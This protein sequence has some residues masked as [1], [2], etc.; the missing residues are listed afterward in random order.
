MTFKLAR[1]VAALMLLGAL[2]RNPYDYYTILR[3]VVCPIAG[4]GAVQANA[5]HDHTW[6]WIFGVIA[7]LHNPIVPVHLSRATWA[8]IDIAC[9][10]ALLVSFRAF[11]AA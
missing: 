3:W 9:A 8:P 5:R 10:V 6:T 11:K 7:A 4:Y 1:L 2:A